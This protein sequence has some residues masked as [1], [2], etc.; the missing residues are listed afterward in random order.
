MSLNDLLDREDFDAK[1]I[2]EPM[3]KGVGGEVLVASAGNPEYVEKLR[4]LQARWR[5]F[6]SHPEA[7]PI[8]EADNEQLW[9]ESIVGTLMLGWRDVPMEPLKPE[10]ASKVGGQPPLPPSGGFLPWSE[11]N[12]LWLLNASTKFRV[13]MVGRVMDEEE[14]ELRHREAIAGNSP[15]PSDGTTGGS[16]TPSTTG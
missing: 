13:H 11:A 15:S 14:F 3:P 1:G 8:P 10:I 2:W 6:N 12:G 4:M 7:K 5:K 16:V 9:R